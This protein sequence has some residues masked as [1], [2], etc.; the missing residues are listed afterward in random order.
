MEKN[1]CLNTVEVLN[2]KPIDGS[3]RIR[4]KGKVNNDVPENFGELDGRSTIL[5]KKSTFFVNEEKDEK[6]S[7]I[8]SAST[9]QSLQ[10]LAITNQMNGTHASNLSSLS[11]TEL[12]RDRLLKKKRLRNFSYNS[13]DLT[14]HMVFY[15]DDSDV[16]DYECYN[17]QDE[18]FANQKKFDCYDF[19]D[20]EFVLYEQDKSN[21]NRNVIKTNEDNIGDELFKE[22]LV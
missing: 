19:E 6:D 14:K 8:V 1:K 10:N 15:Y 16:E 17:N 22:Y 7:N 12:K 11:K 9:D 3:L 2:V 20:Y 18:L 5:S 13:I 4:N 21:P